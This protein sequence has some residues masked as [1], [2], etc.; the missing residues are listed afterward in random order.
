MINKLFRYTLITAGFIILAYIASTAFLLLNE[1][2]MVFSGASLGEQGQ[3]VPSPTAD[4]PWDTLRVQADDGKPVFLLES[5]LEK[6]ETRPWA[7]FFHGNGLLVGSSPCVQRYQLLR[8]AG[9]NVLAVEYRGYG[10]SSELTPSEEGVFAD[11]KAGWRYL[12]QKLS[13]NPNQIVL[14]GWSLG[15]GVATHLASRVQPAG[16]ITEGAFTSLPDVAQD[17]YPWIPTFLLMQNRFNNLAR[18]KSLSLP[19]L[20]LHS[21][22]D[23]IIPFSHA[24]ALA[25]AAE[26]DNL[27]T[28][29]G[30]HNTIDQK[31]ALIALRKFHN[32]IFRNNLSSISPK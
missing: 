31:K 25:A 1:S 7:I 32:R 13:V 16:L 8:E 12:T 15:S 17:I 11:G 5:H 9:F 27:I 19:W 6:S 23:N 2:S 10:I 24:K 18:A 4:I 29:G 22:N 28:L 3:Q 14:Y 30:S 21:R 26:N 20:M